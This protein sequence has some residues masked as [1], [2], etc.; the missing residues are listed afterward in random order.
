ML[1]VTFI[2]GSEDKNIREALDH[3]GLDA[4]KAQ[5]LTDP[6]TYVVPVPIGQYHEAMKRLNRHFI[7]ESAQVF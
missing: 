3:C 4:Q 2:H 7:V 5:P 1:A 6:L